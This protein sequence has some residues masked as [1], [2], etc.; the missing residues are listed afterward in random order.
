LPSTALQRA[1]LGCTAHGAPAPPGKGQRQHERKASDPSEHV[2]I[3]V[4]V[5]GRLRKGR[6]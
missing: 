3:H 4:V 2:D 5:P 6:P 1:P